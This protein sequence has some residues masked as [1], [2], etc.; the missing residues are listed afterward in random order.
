MAKIKKN[1]C[2]K[3]ELIAL[4]LTFAG[5]LQLHLMEDFPLYEVVEELLILAMMDE[6]RLTFVFHVFLNGDIF[7]NI[8]FKG[9]SSPFKILY[10]LRFLFLKN[11]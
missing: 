8:Y 6:S 7:V 11:N 1:T 3:K 10:E 9:Y 4:V 5:L 2:V